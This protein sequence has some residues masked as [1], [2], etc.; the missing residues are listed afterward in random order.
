MMELGDRKKKI[1]K[2]IVTD[3]IET[4]EPVGSRTIAKKYLTDISPATIRNEMA[5]LEDLG[6]LEQPHTSAGRIP[7][8]RGYRYYVD[9]IMEV[10]YPSPQEIE[11]IKY[12]LQIQT[13][14]EL[15]KIIKRTTKL[16]S[17]ITKYTSA[18][19]TPSVRKSSIR[20]LQLIRVSEY[21]IV[22][23]VV[24]DTGIIKNVVIKSPNAVDDAKILKLNNILNDK[25]S[26]L[27]INDIGLTVISDIQSHMRE[28]SEIF[29]AI[30]S[31]VYES[32]K[33][34]DSEIYLE[35]TTNIFDYPE[36]DDKDK[37]RR[38]LSF[39]EDKKLLTNVFSEDENDFCVS[40]GCENGNEKIKD[41][42]IVKATYNIADKTVGTI[43][44][45]GP[46]RMD[47]ARVVG[48]LKSI[49]NIL[50][51]VFEKTL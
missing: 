34:D 8:D 42:S 16:L 29:S 18:V 40:I 37:A 27:T 51:E 4:A 39:I 11:K 38:F 1:L 15:D 26:G 30:I 12:M 3:Y 32:L 9:Q 25:L 5:D 23:V 46:K 6:L 17:D 10:K 14:N 36:Y 31:V 35:G 2:A 44:I 49:S 24:T 47:Y 50:N 41:C 19:L 7:S 20:S 22:A 13:I 28:Y 33:E 45:I 43:G 48:I 21:D